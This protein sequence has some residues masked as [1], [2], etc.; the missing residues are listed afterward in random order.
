MDFHMSY[1]RHFNYLQLN[2]TQQNN[3]NRIAVT[4]LSAARQILPQFVHNAA[5]TGI[6]HNR[7][8]LE[9]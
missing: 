8:I 4:Y 2:N 6:P 3:Q 7:V 1:L 5:F 9:A